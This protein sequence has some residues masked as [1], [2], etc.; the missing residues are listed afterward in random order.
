MAQ[1]I[2]ISAAGLMLFVLAHGLG[3]SLA[4]VDPAAFERYATALHHAW[5]L[6]PLELSLALVALIHLSLTLQ[7]VIIN[8]RARGAVPYDQW[9]SRRSQP[10]AALAGRWSPFSGAVLLL[11]LA[12]HLAQLRWPRPGD[13]LER[14]ALTLALASPWALVLYVLAGVALGLHLLHGAESLARSLGWLDESNAMGL[15]L[16]GRA[17]AAVIGGGFALLPLALRATG[18]LAGAGF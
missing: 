4:L 16:A 7:R 3:A 5:W 13:G 1:A 14:Q 9:R 6:P 17:L 15:R 8:R 11:F 10:L 2:P 12:V 18:P